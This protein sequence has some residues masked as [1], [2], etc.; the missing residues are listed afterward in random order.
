M[1]QLF[2]HATTKEL[3]AAF[4]DRT[5]DQLNSLARYHGLRRPR[6]RLKATGIPIL[7][8]IRERCFELNYSMVDLDALSRSKKYFQKALWNTRSINFAAI[9]KAVVALDG[10]LDVRWRDE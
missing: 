2:P 3:R 7:D 9:G 8:A 5:V 4:P 6:R 10:Q 1:R